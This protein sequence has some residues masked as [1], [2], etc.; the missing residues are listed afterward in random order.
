M[1]YRPRILVACLA[2]LLGVIHLALEYL[3]G[4]V[5]SHHLLNRAD[6][7]AISNGWGLA[8]LPLLGWLFGARF[9][10]RPEPGQRRA[11]LIA[12]AAAALYGAALATAFAHGCQA[13]LPV[14]FF[15]L[16]ALAALLPL[17]RIEFM[18][19]FVVAMTYTF[20]TVLPTLI[21]SVIAL[22]SLALYPLFRYLWR[23]ALR[24]LRRAP[25]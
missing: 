19:G 22:V 11:M 4:G 13:I 3:D 17:Y 14:L 24:A 7:P 10:A 2:L 20:G 21:A 15:G 16:F 9:Q 12:L 1:A 25:G 8:V 18:L 23:M 5:R 6:L